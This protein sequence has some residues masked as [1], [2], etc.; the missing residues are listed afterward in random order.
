MARRLGPHAGVG[1]RA[2]SA[3]PHTAAEIQTARRRVLRH[4][5]WPL[6]YWLRPDDYEALVEG[7]LIPLRLI[8][9]L[10]LDGR[11]VCDIGAGSGRFSLVAA[12]RAQRVVAI[13]AVPELL[14]RLRHTAAE[15]GLHNI[16]T[17]RGAFACLPLADA[18][19]DVAVA[20]SSFMVRG[21][22][23]GVG[24]VREAERIV[25]PGGTVAVIWPHNPRWFAARGYERVHVRGPAAVRFRDIE[26]AVRLCQTFYTP[27]AARWVREHGTAEVPYT[28][29]GVDPPCDV[30]MKITRPTPPTPSR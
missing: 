12:E 24:A 6:V 19:V 4:L 3:Q 26:T 14:R 11:I 21:P 18:S 13:D 1:V 20:C 28:V 27:A 7:E 22:H 2:L 30:C 8:D 29:L 16:E 5:F 10:E 9:E 25:R 23:G 17:K 15:R